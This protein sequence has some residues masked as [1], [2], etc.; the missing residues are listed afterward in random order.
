MSRFSATTENEAFVMR[1][2]AAIGLD[3]ASVE[4]RIVRDRTFLLVQRS[5][6]SRGEDGVVRRIHQEDFCQAPGAPSETKYASEAAPL[7]RTA[8]SFPAASPPGQRLMCL[9]CLTPRFSI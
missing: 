9:S 2:A 1:L 4:T 8:L 5:D 3:V 6:R 7:S